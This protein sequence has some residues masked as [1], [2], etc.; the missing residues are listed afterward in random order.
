M[1]KNSEHSSSG[2]SDDEEYYDEEED[3]DRDEVNE[4][5][6]MSSK[7]TSRIFIWRVVVTLVLLLT[8]FTVTFASFTFL[9]RQ[10]HENFK[11]AVSCA[12]LLLVKN[13]FINRNSESV[14]NVVSLTFPFQFDQFSRTVGNAAVDQQR[15]MDGTLRSFANF[16]SQSAYDVNATWPLYMFPNYELHAKAVRKQSGLEVLNVIHNIKDKDV[17]AALQFVNQTYEKWIHES[18]LTLYGTTDRLSPIKYHTNLTILTKEGLV[19]DTVQRDQHYA[20]WLY[21]PRKLSD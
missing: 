18:H 8:A 13:Y 17:H 14:D 15:A 9:Q 1:D 2:N 5:R 12:H 11:T 20:V 21:S 10:E 16:Y 4:V 7:D 6:K 19:P 3:V